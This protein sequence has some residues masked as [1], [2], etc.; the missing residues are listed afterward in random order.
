L[1]SLCAWAIK[2]E[3]SIIKVFSTKWRRLGE[4]SQMRLRGK[5]KAVSK[6]TL[7]GS[8]KDLKHILSAIDLLRAFTEHLE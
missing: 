7:L 3:I 6:A 1:A 5:A 4:S 2:L 8:Q